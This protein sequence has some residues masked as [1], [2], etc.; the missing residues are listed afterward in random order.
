MIGETT[1]QYDLTDSYDGEWLKELGWLLEK[2]IDIA[3]R[4]ILNAVLFA[5]GERDSYK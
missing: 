5:I 4:E 3:T 2:P 1:V